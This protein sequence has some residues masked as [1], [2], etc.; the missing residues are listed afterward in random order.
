MDIN[1]GI[2]IKERMC[3]FHT[4]RMCSLRLDETF[5]K[6]LDTYKSR[7]IANLR[8]VDQ[9]QTLEKSTNCKP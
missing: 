4:L 1:T 8:K 7:P 6:E 5:V 2:Y 3:I 9:S